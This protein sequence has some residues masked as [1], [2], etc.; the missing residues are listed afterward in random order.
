[1][2]H[3]YDFLAQTGGWEQDDNENLLYFYGVMIICDNEESIVIDASGSSYARYCNRLCNSNSSLESILSTLETKVVIN[4]DLYNEAMK[5]IIDTELYEISTN[6]KTVLKD[7]RYIKNISAN[8]LTCVTGFTIKEL[9]SQGNSINILNL[10]PLK[11]KL[12]LFMEGLIKHD[13]KQVISLFPT[14]LDKQMENIK[15]MDRLQFEM[16][17]ATA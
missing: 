13:N 9:I 3:D 2:L 5:S 12:E 6:D 10:Q 8:G 4:N 15:F 7:P 14:Q 11:F 17:R 16:N 1:M